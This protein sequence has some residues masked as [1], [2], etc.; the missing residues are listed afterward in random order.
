MF[1]GEVDAA[2]SSLSIFFTSFHWMNL[3]IFLRFNPVA[4]T[5]MRKALKNFVDRAGWPTLQADTLD[6]V[7][8]SSNGDIRSAVHSLLFILRDPAMSPILNRESSRKGKG[9]KGRAIK[10]N[11]SKVYVSF[12]D[13]KG[14]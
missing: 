13:P 1:L 10:Q 4:P 3:T 8:S 5:L 11:D 14:E 2:K 9:R 6:S 12:I 7:I